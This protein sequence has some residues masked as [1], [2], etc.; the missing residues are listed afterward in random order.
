[1][2]AS[3]PFARRGLLKAGVALTS[4][5]TVAFAGRAA[6]APAGPAAPAAPRSGELADLERRYGARLGVYARNTRTGRVLAHRAGERFAMCSVFKAFAAAAVLRDEARCAPM[7]K[8]IHYPPHDLLPNSPRT[9]ENQATG[10]AM[11]D[12]CAAAIQYSDNAAGNLLLRQLDGPAG[13]TRFFRS[14][15][16]DV[17][18]LDRWEPELNTA[19][20]GDPRDT[21]SPE[22]LAA[23]IERL[24]LGRALAAADRERFV[25]WL[26]GNT[27]SGARFR[28]GLPEG[29]TIADKTGTGDYASAN[30]MG[31]AW[32]TRRT[33][34][35]LAVLSTKEGANDKDAPVD[36]ALIAE[37]ARIA[38]RTVAPGE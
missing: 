31:V 38:A 27:T 32:T 35:V 20:P 28:A 34:V 36:E 22:A 14:L 1:M 8:V 10:M 24:A 15:G 25:G 12:V 9:Q 5:A 17:S 21:T 4:A 13:L 19:I 11:A 33:P 18:R 30:D 37:A 3:G 26:K 2:T 7:D 29:W 16:D 23:S 6:A